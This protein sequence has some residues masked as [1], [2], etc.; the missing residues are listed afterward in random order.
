M[1]NSFYDLVLS[2][3]LFS[4][5]F[6]F[7]SFFPLRFPSPSPNTTINSPGGG[8]VEL[9]TGLIFCFINF[10]IELFKRLKTIIQI[11]DSNALHTHHIYVHCYGRKQPRTVKTLNISAGLLFLWFLLFMASLKTHFIIFF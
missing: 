5:T 4:P 1:L 8:D 7:F 2:K 3:V 11:P 9:Y 10:L 6:L